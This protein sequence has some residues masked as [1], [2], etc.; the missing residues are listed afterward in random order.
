VGVCRNVQTE[1]GAG[2]CRAAPA[3][4]NDVKIE[5]GCLSMETIRTEQRGKLT[6]RMLRDKVGYAGVVLSDKGRQALLRGTDKEDLWHRLEQA[7]AQSSKEYVGFEGARARFFRLY[8]Q[9][10]TTPRYWQDERDYKLKAKA[11]LDASVP[12]AQA[13][14]G[15]GLGELVL[16]VFRATNLLAP[17]EMMR[18]QDLLRSTSADSF[19]HAAAQFACGAGAQA[20][21]EMAQLANPHEAAKWTVVTYLPYLW[22]PTTHMFLK[23]GVTKDFAER[24]GHSFVDRYTTT[25]DIAV[26]DSLLDLV[27][28]TEQ[29]IA[30]LKPQDRIDVQSF[31]WVVGAYTDA[32]LPE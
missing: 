9:G 29:E 5:K 19:I 17:F 23:P 20:L 24:V 28:T 4:P 22:L 8:P 10:F 13:L 27:A 14:C 6:L 30:D 26:Y 3:R 31:I 11:K 12:L 7:A 25:I 1:Q 16:A 18:V 15:K 32:D 2:H 21:K